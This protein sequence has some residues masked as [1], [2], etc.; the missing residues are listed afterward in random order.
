MTIPKTF[1]PFLCPPASFQA[2]PLADEEL[3]LTWLGTAGFK[4]QS[5]RTT[6][7]IDPFFSRI[8]L[9]NL[10]F[11]K[12]QPHHQRIEYH[13]EQTVPHCDAIIVGHSHYDHVMDVPYIAQKTGAT[14]IG[15]RST[16]TLMRSA[17]LPA[18]Q[19]QTVRGGDQI[20]V[21]DINVRFITSRHS[22]FLFGRIPYPGEIEPPLKLPL[23]ASGYRCGE[24]FGLQI[25]QADFHF[26]HLGSCDLIEENMETPPIDVFLM[27]ISGRHNTPDFVSRVIRKLRPRLVIPHH[28]DSFFQPI[29]KG[30]RMLPGM[31]CQKLVEEVYAVDQGIKI[32]VIDLLQ[33]IRI[34]TREVKEKPDQ[35][36]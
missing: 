3:A 10:L 5:K 17:G 16:A 14:V 23:K 30:L 34:K 32:Q 27:G 21:G 6:L 1:R 11:R 15:S 18:S 4:L 19:I 31:Q 33:E 8:S 25:S 12:L 26:Y 13:L 35:K 36:L 7:L 9:P 28:F 24:V 2:I 20:T 22:A 29:E